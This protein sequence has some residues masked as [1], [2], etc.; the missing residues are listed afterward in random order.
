MKFLELAKQGR[1]ST[2]LY[3]GGV[4][5]LIVLYFVGNLP[6]LI[7]LKLNYPT[8]LFNPEHP[9]FI[10]HYGSLRLFIGMLVPFVFLFIGLVLYLR[11]AH[12]RQL[13]SVFSA[14]PRFRWRRFF[15]FGALLIVLF[16]CISLLEAYLSGQYHQLSWNFKAES[17]F[18]LLVVALLLVPLQA[19]AEELIFRV[20]ALQG[21]YLRTK[22]AWLS[23]VLS[24]LLFA[25]MHVSNPEINAMGPGLLLYYLMAG[26]F[27]ALISVQDDGLELALAF[28]IFNNL[29]GSLIMSSTWQVFHTEALFLDHRPPGTLTYHLLSGLVTFGCLYFIL[30]KKFKWK[31]LQSLR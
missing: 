15:V 23:I 24:A 11:F 9:A 13:V 12:Q 16:T 28:H 21:L 8:L 22:N 20:Y 31:A 5:L 10:A 17:F 6:L 25:L 14:A 29:F 27:L 18:G 30:A 26:I 19:A 2:G 1:T 3:L 4:L 7:D